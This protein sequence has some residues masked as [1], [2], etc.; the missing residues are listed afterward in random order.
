MS[1][2]DVQVG[3]FGQNE[4]SRIAA[5]LRSIDVAIGDR[6]ALVTLILNGSTDASEAIAR[7]T[8]IAADLRIYRIRQ[9]DKSNAINRFFY[10]LRE[11][12]K[13]Y[14]CVDA[15]VTISPGAVGAFEQR[16][17]GCPTAFV[18]T[19]VAGNGRSEP[20]SNRQTI[21]QGG[22]IHGQLYALRPEFVQRIVDAGIRLPL[23]LYRGDGLIG[24]MACL[25]LDP[26][27]S[28]WTNA[29][30]VGTAGALFEIDALSVLKLRDLR[31]QF[32]R[33]IRQMRGVL[34]NAAIKR[35]I[36]RGGYGALP[37]DADDMIRTDLA[38]NPIPASSVIDRPFL[39]LALRQHRRAA[40][41]RA[42]DL[43]PVRV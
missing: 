27:A 19:G 6:R 31:R 29:R 28:T 22:V 7:A 10:E 38:D 12:A 36:Q 18:A 41:A 34:E 14:I 16:I 40:R 43:E 11:P 33:K 20:K 13:L 26:L 35:V 2:Y 32:R 37:D 15:Y 5:C 9:A 24:S 1:G 4:A 3:V 39:A 21:E 25:D 23:A 17:A 42:A 8:N 30:L